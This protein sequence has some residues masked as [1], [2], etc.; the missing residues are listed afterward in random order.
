AR[1]VWVQSVARE[2]RWQEPIAVGHAAPVI[3]VHSAV[4]LAIIAQPGVQRCDLRKRIS[5]SRFANGQ[6]RSEQY[7]YV[8]L[9]RHLCH[10]RIIAFN[11]PDW[12]SCAK[13]IY[14]GQDHD[15]PRLESHYVLVEAQDHL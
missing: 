4:A 7:R 3:N 15:G 11:L 5:V 12:N 13:I 8:V 2:S 10:R 14:S 1:S 6:K 9:S